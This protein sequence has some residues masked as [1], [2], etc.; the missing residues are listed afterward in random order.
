MSPA[1]LQWTDPITRQRRRF[2][3]GEGGA[4]LVIGRQPGVSVQV[5][6]KR[7]SR[8]HAM[9]SLADGVWIV[10]DL[11]STLGTFFQR[12]GQTWQR[13]S[14]G[15]A[16]RDRDRLRLGRTVIEFLDPPASV[17]NVDAGIYTAGP[18]F[19]ITPR[20]MEVLE[21]LCEAV[22]HQ[23]RRLPTDRELGERFV[24][25]PSTIK[26][27]VQNLMQKFDVGERGLLVRRAIDEGW[28]SDPRDRDPPPSPGLA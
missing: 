4:S 22:F 17:S 5:S 2:V 19:Q 6:D 3:L 16:L 26:T 9:L 18:D 1:S 7:M 28:V 14:S 12:D 15:L 20:E 11:Q 24:L 23:R 8:T 21:A 10:S 25:A 27:H 13:L